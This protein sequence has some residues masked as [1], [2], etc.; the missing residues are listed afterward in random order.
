MS[1]PIEAL[2]GKFVALLSGSA[3]TARGSVGAEVLL[4]CDR[5]E[6]LRNQGFSQ[7][8]S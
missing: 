2:A 7:A 3:L 5:F 1:R 6:S 4:S 8:T